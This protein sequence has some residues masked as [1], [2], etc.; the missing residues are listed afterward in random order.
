MKRICLIS[1]A[2]AAGLAPASVQAE[3][4]I[5]YVPTEAVTLRPTGEG[6]CGG[7]GGQVNSALGCSG[8]EAEVEE[9]AYADA[10]NLTDALTTG[11]AAYDIAV[12]NTRPPEYISYTMLLASDEP[13][14]K[15]NMSFTCAYG[16]INC[17]ALKRNDIIS[18]SGDTTN[19]ITPEIVHSAMYAFGRISGLEG[20][21]N[22]EDWMNYPPDYTVPPMGFMDV[23]NDR[24][25]QF[26][27]ND[28][29]D[30]VELPLE[31][32][33]V[34]HARCP[35]GMNGDPGQNSHQDLLMWYGE[36]VVDE[37]P[38]EL[39]NIV[40]EDG[41]VLMPGDDLV[42]DVDIADADAVVGARWTI[43]SD[44]IMGEMFPE[45]ILTQC[46]NDVCD[47]NWD[48]AAPLKPTD[49]D[50][51]VSLVGL[52]AGDYAITLEAADYHG[53]VAEMVTINVS[54]MG[55]DPATSTGS[56]GAEAGND[57]TAGNAT[58]SFT[59]GADGSGGSGDGGADGGADD[60]GAGGCS[61][62][63]DSAP[64]GFGFMLLG[65]MGLGVM[66]RRW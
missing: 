47:F 61:C 12:T 18:T 25:N 39:T 54:I 57:E 58:N 49:S 52:P 50:W 63:T 51:M 24:V 62:T 42:L 34:D 5:L 30:Q 3:P 17:N 56:G 55:D 43:Q 22:P 41:T 53:N 48:D 8:V 20:V 60:D 46:T 31:C 6:V 14:S 38:P 44:A 16:G 15:T 33:S 27:F 7:M 23:C 29:G 37:D 66:R 59:T 32:T 13:G 26:G 10:A 21:T 4:A 28:K 45:G 19:C 9:P 2:L 40:P 64:G 35:D 1:C 11:L 65:L 36:P